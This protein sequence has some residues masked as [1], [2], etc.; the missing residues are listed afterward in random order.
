[1]SHANGADVKEES[2]RNA[3]IPFMMIRRVINDKM[4]P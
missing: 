1:M 4:A 2:A 3:V